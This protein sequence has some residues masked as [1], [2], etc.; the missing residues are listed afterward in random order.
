MRVNVDEGA[1]RVALRATAWCGNRPMLRR[2]NRLRAMAVGG[3]VP[4]KLMGTSKT[5]A[6]NAR[7]L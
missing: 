5:D 4:M 7:S 2:R 6:L 1:G 3:R